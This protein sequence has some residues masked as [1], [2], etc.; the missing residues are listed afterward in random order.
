MDFQCSIDL[1]TSYAVKEDKRA[2]LSAQ[3]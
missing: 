1:S 3:L 2:L